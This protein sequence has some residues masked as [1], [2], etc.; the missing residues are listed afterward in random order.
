MD[1]QFRAATRKGRIDQQEPVSILGERSLC[2]PGWETAH[3]LN[4]N[5]HQG[6]VKPLISDFVGNNVGWWSGRQPDGWHL[7]ENDN[8]VGLRPTGMV[9]LV[10]IL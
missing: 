1:S 10:E 6:L 3:L 4:L 9:S 8:S 2:Q 5:F 7:L